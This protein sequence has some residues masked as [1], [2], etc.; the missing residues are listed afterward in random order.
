MR[1]QQKDVLSEAAVMLKIT[2]F[3]EGVFAMLEVC[4][5]PA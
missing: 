2:G 3:L 5:V 4:C 1:R